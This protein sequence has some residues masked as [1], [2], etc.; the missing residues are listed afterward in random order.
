MGLQLEDGT[1]D[2]FSAKVNKYNELLTS[3]DSKPIQHVISVRDGQSYQVIGDFTSINNSTHTVLHIKNTSSSRNL[4]I[5]Y[6]RMQTIDL[7]GG[8]APPS[9]TNYWQI[10]TGRTVSSGGSTVTPVNVNFS[11]GNTADVTATDNNPTMSGTF[12]ELDRYY[13]QSEGDTVTYNKE[14][15]IIIGKD[16]T[17]EIRIVASST[18]GTAYA[19]VS[20]YEEDVD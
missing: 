5:T 20:F 2:G 19:R 10:G 17:L 4:V 9:A 8:T 18:S 15:S 16:D 12:T 3:A 14:G 7:A 11:S 13:I 6:I 1:G